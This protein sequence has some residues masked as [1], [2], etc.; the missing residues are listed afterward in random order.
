[1]SNSGAWAP[2]GLRGTVVKSTG[3][4]PRAALGF[5]A[6][7][8]DGPLPMVLGSGIITSGNLA[9]PWSEIFP[10][11]TRVV[12]LLAAI[13]LMSLAD[14][15]MTLCYTRSVGMAES[16][17]IARLIIGTQSI[18]A[19]VCFKVLTSALGV[20]LLFRLRRW[21]SAELGAWILLGVMGWLMVRWGIY[22]AGAPEVYGVTPAHAQVDDPYWVHMPE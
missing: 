17:P 11:S 3:R 6:P 5:D 1:M 16:N 15:D 12:L 13:V 20:G 21:R 18:S 14:L 7:Q 19:V 22:N 4:I 10:R 8:S 9:R 2:I